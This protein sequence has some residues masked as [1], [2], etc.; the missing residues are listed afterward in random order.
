M[1]DIIYVIILV[2]YQKYPSNKILKHANVLAKVNKSPWG[3]LHNTT[4]NNAYNIYN[5]C[6]YNDPWQKL[7]MNKKSN[8]PI[9]LKIGG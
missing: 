1:A 4:P 9:I 5:P 6:N 2:K 8:I 3:I 7:A